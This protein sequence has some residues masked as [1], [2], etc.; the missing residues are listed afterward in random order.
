M[1]QTFKSFT[2]FVPFFIFLF[3]YLLSYTR[4]CKSSVLLNV[5]NINENGVKRIKS[6]EM[7]LLLQCSFFRLLFEVLN[8]LLLKGIKVISKTT[9]VSILSTS[10]Q[11]TCRTNS[12]RQ[13][14]YSILYKDINYRMA[15][16]AL[17]L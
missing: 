7:F 1:H 8:L 16:V 5:G 6:S 17:K 4:Q 13:V 11:L 3:I 2:A 15:F 10:T 12:T 9:F 14:F